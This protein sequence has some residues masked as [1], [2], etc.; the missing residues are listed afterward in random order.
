MEGG[1][2][3][4]CAVSTPPTGPEFGLRKAVRFTFEIKSTDKMLQLVKGRKY[5]N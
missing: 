2:V 1:G 5:L 3:Q 4:D